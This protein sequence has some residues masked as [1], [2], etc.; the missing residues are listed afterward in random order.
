MEYLSTNV[1]FVKGNL[2]FKIIFT[3][4]LRM[5]GF[6]NDSMLGLKIQHP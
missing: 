6:V 2:P 3:F 1:S 4:P 5:S